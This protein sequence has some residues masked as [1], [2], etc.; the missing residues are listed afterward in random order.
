MNDNLGNRLKKYRVFKKLKSGEL[1]DITGI[2]R[3]T[4]S[5]I[6]HG[7]IKPRSETTEKLFAKTDI[8]PTWLLT[9]EGPMC[10]ST[11]E[12]PNNIKHHDHAQII[13]LFHDTDWAI[14]ANS[15]L[16]ETEK[17]GERAKGEVLGFLKGVLRATQGH[18]VAPA[19]DPVRILA[20]SLGGK[21]EANHSKK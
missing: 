20:E 13:P 1:A 14:E 4:V 17:Q 2:S 9:G 21:V 16:V 3:A 5:E 8:N 10:R 19:P 18:R 15:L 12:K 6:E 7:K 11:A